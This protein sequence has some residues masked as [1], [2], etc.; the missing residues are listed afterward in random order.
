[1]VSHVK[2]PSSA[3]NSKLE[4]NKIFKIRIQSA[5]PNSLRNLKRINKSSAF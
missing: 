3:S 4:N 1:M 2:R 5:H